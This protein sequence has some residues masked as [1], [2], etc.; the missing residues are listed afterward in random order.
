MQSL[1]DRGR[2]GWTSEP[3][4]LEV[5][6]EQVRVYTGFRMRAQLVHVLGPN[7]AVRVAQLVQQAL[8]PQAT[9]DQGRR[10]ILK[11]GGVLLIGALFGP[12]I[13]PNNTSLQS[14]A[15]NFDVIPLS[16]DDPVIEKLKQC[17]SVQKA[18]KNFGL[19][20]W[21]NVHKIQYKDNNNI[22]YMIVYS[23]DKPAEAN[24]NH[25]TTFLMIGDPDRKLDG[26]AIVGR[27]K[28]KQEK[29]L[30]VTWLTPEAQLVDATTINDGKVVESSISAQDLNFTCFR[31]CLRSLGLVLGPQCVGFCAVCATVPTPFNPA[32][33]V[34]AACIGGVA[35]GCIVTCWT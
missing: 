1:L 28:Q 21:E 14:A 15:P 18:E 6:D 5:Q 25:K 30:Q 3:T 19:P 34:C 13:L 16:P 31:G 33:Y 27:M 24:G 29:E 11:R 22:A 8:S 20:S 32:C 17:E 23:K 2:P 10:N 7:R 26:K 9:V 35:F 12:K 4:L